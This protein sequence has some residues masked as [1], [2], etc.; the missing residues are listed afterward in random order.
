MQFSLLKI[1]Q[2]QYQLLISVYIFPKL[3]KLSG[4]APEI[5]GHL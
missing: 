3:N 5:G 1:K 2:K 4:D